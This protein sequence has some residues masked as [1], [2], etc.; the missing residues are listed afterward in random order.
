MSAQRRKSNGRVKDR[1]HMLR[2][3][4]GRKFRPNHI[5][6]AEQTGP[7]ECRAL[8]HKDG[9]MTF[10]GS[11]FKRMPPDK[12]RHL[13]SKFF[14]PREKTEASE[15][16]AMVEVNAG[17]RMEEIRAFVRDQLV[18]GTASSSRIFAAAE[19]RKFEPNDVIFAAKQIGV[20]FHGTGDACTWSLWVVPEEHECVEVS[21]VDVNPGDPKEETM[22]QEQGKEFKKAERF[23][24]ERHGRMLLQ[25]VQDFRDAYPGISNPEFWRKFGEYA[26]A[27][28]QLRRWAANAYCWHSRHNV[29]TFRFSP[30]GERQRKQ[31][32]RIELLLKS[33]GFMAK[34]IY[35]YI[36][37][38]GS[39][40]PEQ[41]CARI[42]WNEGALERLA[43]LFEVSVE[44]IRD[45]IVPEEKPA[46]PPAPSDVVPAASFAA[47]VSMFAQDAADLQR[48]RDV[49]ARLDQLADAGGAL[50]NAALR[51]TVRHALGQ[52]A[53]A[54]LI[55]RQIAAAR[56]R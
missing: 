30:A 27:S 1:G 16:V 49:F 23:S 14:V 55:G 41:L 32:D 25:I 56:G 4:N 37:E 39:Q 29:A 10:S 47:S 36:D 22:D 28:D 46:A 21:A 26:N 5:I 40:A 45:G 52:D 44:Y 35:S 18:G 6:V 20:Q 11:N 7:C 17:V 2:A 15:E 43:A 50:D 38:H 13:R 19:Q 3:D 8:V 34:E 42:P 12:F 24:N 31:A 48:M 51:V 9:W 33:H 54:D 53:F